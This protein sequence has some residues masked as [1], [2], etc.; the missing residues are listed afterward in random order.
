M[1]LPHRRHTFLFGFYFS[2]TFLM[3]TATQDRDKYTEFGIISSQLGLTLSELFFNLKFSRLG[4]AQCAGHCPVNRK[5]AGYRFQVRAHTWVVG[6]VPSWGR[7]RGNRLISIY[8]P[9][10]FPSPF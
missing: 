4:L 8:L 10:F 9:F 2:I 7:V 5:V 6:Q 1:S 3:H